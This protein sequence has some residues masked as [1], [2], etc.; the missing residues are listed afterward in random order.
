[1]VV[2][3][4]PSPTP[5]AQ[6]ETGRRVFSVRLEWGMN[7]WSRNRPTGA[8]HG[9]EGLTPPSFSITRSACTSP[10]VQGKE[11]PDSA[12]HALATRLEQPCFRVPPSATAGVASAS[13]VRCRDEWPCPQEAA[14][15]IGIILWR[16]VKPNPCSNGSLPNGHSLN[17]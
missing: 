16:R 4:A 9:E 1:M 8:C 13:T 2:F 12:S 3:T 11:G 7:G 15:P 14:Q 10:P 17:P 5:R 6:N